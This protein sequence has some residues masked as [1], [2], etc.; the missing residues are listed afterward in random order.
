MKLNQFAV[1]MVFLSI[2]SG[3]AFGVVIATQSPQMTAR[4]AGLEYV[5]NPELTVD[6]SPY[7]EGE[8]RWQLVVL[9]Y[10]HCPDVCPTTMAKLQ[11]LLGTNQKPLQVDVLFVSVDP[12]RD[13]ARAAEAFAKRFGQNF[14][15]TSARHGE[16]E[17][18]TRQLGL[19]YRVPDDSDEFYLVTHSPVIT[20]VNPVGQIRGRLRPGFALKQTR[21]QLEQLL[22]G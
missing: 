6:L 21:L 4:H 13:S 12:G 18:L 16:L 5:D 11:Q 15:G 9:G 3:V 22:K 2:F 1:P 20:L 8:G 10:L 17:G 14:F 7:F 19:G